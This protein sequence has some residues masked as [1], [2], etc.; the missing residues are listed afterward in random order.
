MTHPT[1]EMLKQY[2]TFWD[3]QNKRD[4]ELKLLA[5]GAA[6]SPRAARAAKEHQYDFHGEMPRTGAKKKGP[7]PRP[8]SSSSA[9]SRPSKS[10]PTTAASPSMWMG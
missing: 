10:A 5:Q 1:K 2:S 6:L 7:A 8:P 9:P 3:K 4:I